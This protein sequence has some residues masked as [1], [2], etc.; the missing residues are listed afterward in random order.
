MTFTSLTFICFLPLVF[1]LYWL[2]KK[3]ERQN[4]LLIITSY[5][6]YGWWD[7]RFCALILFSSLLDFGL[8]WVLGQ[9]Q[10]E[11]R[12]K[13]LLAASVIAN[14]GLLGLFKY[15]NFFADSF[16]AMT[17]NFGWSPDPTTLNLILPVGIS[18]YTFQTLSYTIDIYRRQIRATHNLVDYLAFVSF[19]PQLVAGP[20]ERAANLLPQFSAPRAFDS[21]LARSGCRLILWGF[22]KKMVIA[23]RL[24]VIV[25]EIYSDPT[26]FGGPLLAFA[27]VAFA[28]Q[29]YCDF[30]AYSDIAIGTARLFSIR[31][32]RNFAYPY[33]SQSVSEFWRRWHVSLSTWFRDY[34]YIPMGGSRVSKT[35]RSINLLT[36]FVVSGF[37]HGAGWQ[38]LAWGGIH[39]SAVAAGYGSRKPSESSPKIKTADDGSPTPGGERFIPSFRTAGKILLTFSIVCLCWVFFRAESIGDALLIVGKIF[40]DSFSAAGWQELS[41]FADKG[42][43]VKRAII[44]VS[45]LVLLEW[46]QRR[47]MCPLDMG[48]T[49]KPI[50]WAAYTT[51]IW[52]TAYFMMPSAG[53]QFIYFDF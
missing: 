25:D 19:F 33:F 16:S 2:L 11:R 53:Q 12:R 18:F 39:G 41:A 24:S 42:K 8:G 13:L 22:F 29:I 9:S 20:I 30:S 51:L 7:Y 21:S 3:P 1:S 50:R 5:I 40:T 48:S 38:Y 17:T 45:V 49:P 34:V 26:A 36:T 15:F 52:F 27:T 35:Q 46:I 10:S 44:V 28:F 6:F 47:K 32:M 23:D 14:V 31:L 43:L 4:V 37:W